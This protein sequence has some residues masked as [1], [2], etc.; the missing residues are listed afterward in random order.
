[1]RE[2]KLAAR[3]AEAR[4]ALRTLAVRA[5]RAWG[6]KAMRA[7]RGLPVPGETWSLNEVDR[8]CEE[9]LGQCRGRRDSRTAAIRSELLR[10]KRVLDDARDQLILA[11][12][13]LVVHIAKKYTS[14][15]IALPDLVQEGNLGLMKAV[16]KFDHTRGNRFTT[17]AYWWIKQAIERGIG[18]QA[19]TV[20]VPVHVQ[21]KLRRIRQASERLRKRRSREPTAEEI[22]HE[23][24][25]AASKVSETQRLARD[26]A[27]LEDPDRVTDLLQK[28]ADPRA[29]CPFEQTLRQQTRRNL[30]TALGRLTPRERRVI[31]LR[32][33]LDGSG[34]P[35]LD[36]V[37]E[38][39]QLPREQVR[40][41]ERRALA[42]MA[43]SPATEGL[44]D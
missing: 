40:R 8:F 38:E 43:A 11:N 20:R 30:E 27:P 44:A 34:R 4:E 15:G 26:T 25:I 31:R 10:R 6:R 19:R 13:R 22:A 24:G 1:V 42:K 9:L 21:D 14:N 28:E 39:L 12:L 17:Y 29:V 23:L 32:F 36:S 41:I 3:V 2:A 37:G 16:D 18:N 5:E 7:A 33:G 35:T